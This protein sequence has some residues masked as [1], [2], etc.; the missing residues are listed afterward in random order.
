MMQAVERYADGKG[1]KW[2]RNRTSGTATT[3]SQPC[4]SGPTV[5]VPLKGTI[6]ES[7]KMTNLFTPFSDRSTP[8][9]LFFSDSSGLSSALVAFHF[10]VSKTREPET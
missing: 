6:R 1:T 5:L 10:W 3:A 8:Q 9:G 2:S 7:C 4:P